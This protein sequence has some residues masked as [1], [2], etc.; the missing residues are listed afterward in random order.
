[1]WSKKWS[2]LLLLEKIGM[3]IIL[4]FI[5]QNISLLKNNPDSDTLNAVN[6]LYILFIVLIILIGV[7]SIVQLLL[8]IKQ[9]TKQSI[10]ANTND[11]DER[12]T[13]DKL[14]AD[15]QKTINEKLV[16]LKSKLM[17]D[18]NISKKAEL[19]I[20]TLA[21]N[22]AA[23]QGAV[24]LTKK[25]K[26]IKKL[27][28]IAGYAYYLPESKPLEFEFGEGL[29]GQVAVNKKI[30]NLTNALETSPVFSG[31]GS[32]APTSLI[33]CP[34]KNKDEVRGVF[35]LASFKI[36]SEEDELYVEKAAELFNEII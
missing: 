35:E 19:F 7:F 28:F 3:V 18:A 29:T 1:M 10:A 36:F 26:E 31:L 11:A 34:I 22:L 14:S 15:V 17:Q 13:T 25:D 8:Y 5:Y 9:N 16:E 23:S 6:E 21:A 24:F 27:S 33:I 30:I 32:A 20:N 4:F 2:T 12:L